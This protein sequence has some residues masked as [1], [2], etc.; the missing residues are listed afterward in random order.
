MFKTLFKAELA[1]SKNYAL[2]LLAG[3]LVFFVAGLYAGGSAYTFAGISAIVFWII[4][5]ANYSTYS[6]Q[7]R[8]RLY[9]QLPTTHFDVFF[10]SWAVVLLWLSASF[11]F[12]LAYEFIVDPAFSSERIVELVTSALGILLFTT[13]V[14]I[15]IDLAAFKP[16][17]VQWVYIASLVL[18]GVIAINLDWSSHIGIR[19]SDDSFSVFPY[20]FAS[21]GPIGILYAAATCAVFFYVNYKVYEKSESFLH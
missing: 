1:G 8:C 18:F 10:A 6:D 4:L 3:N 20:D 9:T 19:I 14:S 2:L 12:W 11:G 13:L 17:S 21:F 5:T 15:A 7:R 16:R